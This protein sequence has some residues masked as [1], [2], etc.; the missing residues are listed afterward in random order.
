MTKFVLIGGG[1]VGRGNTEY[2]TENIDKEIVKITEKENPNFLFIGLASNF[3][4]SYYDTMKKIYKELGCN[5]AYLKKKNILNNPDIVKNKIENADIIYFCGGD[6]IKLVKDL[7]EYNID[8]LLEQKI[9]NDNVVI[10]GMSAGAIMLSKYGYSD[11]LKLRDESDK[12]DFVEGLGFI[13]IVF[14]PHYKEDSEKGKELKEDLK[15]KNN[16]VVALEDNCALKIFNNKYEIIKEKEEKN[17]F[18]CTYDNKFICKKLNNTG[19][20]EELR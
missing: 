17:A 18:L 6:S 12:Y 10:A 4:D 14:C 5:C 1:N 2:E 19:T 7:K 9:V 16:K 8:K 20:I 13:D 15:L 11:S 3:S